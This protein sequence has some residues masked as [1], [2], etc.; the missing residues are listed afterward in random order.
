MTA[1]GWETHLGNIDL[2][3]KQAQAELKINIK[4]LEVRKGM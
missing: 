1:D 3:G 2:H 4:G